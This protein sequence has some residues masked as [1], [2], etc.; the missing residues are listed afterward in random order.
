MLHINARWPNLCHV[1]YTDRR[2][3]I[4]QRV[5]EALAEGG[6][7]QQ[8]LSATTGIPE[9]TLARR[10]TGRTNWTVD[11]LDAIAD[12]LSVPVGSLVA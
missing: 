12:A 1:A 2:Q 8:A 11:E 6:T 5:R 4:A 10:L 3:A 9:R 7:S